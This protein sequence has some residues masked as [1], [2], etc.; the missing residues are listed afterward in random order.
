M[1]REDRSL[2]NAASGAYVDIDLI[3]EVFRDIHSI[4]G[5]AGFLGL[6]PWMKRLVHRLQPSMID[7]RIDLRGR[8]AGVT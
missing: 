3:N 2:S 6:R 1:T 4:K 7:M 8:D 5:A